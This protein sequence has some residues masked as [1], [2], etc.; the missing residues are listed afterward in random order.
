MV[1]MTLDTS[2]LDQ[3]NPLVP[4][5]LAADLRRISRLDHS[6]RP[7]GTDS[8][9]VIATNGTYCDSINYSFQYGRIE[10]GGVIEERFVPVGKPVEYGHETLP[11]LG[12]PSRSGF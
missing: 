10:G 3:S 6:G 9:R 1:R 12:Q 2:K 11:L 5:G 7:S 4:L 8:V